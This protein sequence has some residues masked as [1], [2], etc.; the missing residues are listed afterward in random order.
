MISFC[1]FLSS[2]LYAI[3]F[4]SIL[5][6]AHEFGHFYVALKHG[7]RAKEFSVGMGWKLFSTRDKNGTIWT[8]RSIPFGGYVSFYET[9]INGKTIDNISLIR[10]I[11]VYLAGPAANLIVAFLAFNL[12]FVIRGIPK[13]R[14]T[15]KNTEII[16]I[17][18]ELPKV[19][20]MKI[21]RNSSEYESLEN[22]KVGLQTSQGNLVIDIGDLKNNLISNIYYFRGSFINIIRASWKYLADSI[23]LNLT[24]IFDLFSGKKVNVS[25]PI[26]ILHASKGIAKSFS[27]A[28]EW[29]AMV[30][31]GLAIFNLMP[32]VPLDG[33]RIVH[34]LLSRYLGKKAA[35][36]Y[37]RACLVLFYAMIIYVFSKDINKIVSSK[38]I[39]HKKVG[40]LK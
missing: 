37:E 21:M 28:L 14:F 34:D 27:G 33:G 9:D 23:R 5:V 7:V 3:L 38:I 16:S 20:I 11:T 8:F 31:I 40:L 6:I 26:G 4:I 32:F 19:S 2:Y 13:I 25:G 15:Y 39:S 10:R 29:I 12:M 30:S 22:R 1:I 35:A 18:N 36:L 24:S 17:N